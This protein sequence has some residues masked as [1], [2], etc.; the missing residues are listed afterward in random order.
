MQGAAEGTIGPEALEALFDDAVRDTLERFEA[1]GSP[2]ITDGEQRKQ[3]FATYPVADLE[4]ITTGGVTIPFE[5]G[6]ARQLPLITAGPFRYATPAW[7]YLDGARPHTSTKLKQAVISASAVSLMYPPDALPGYPREAFVDDLVAEAVAEI[8]GCLE[9]GADVQ[10]D[11]TE[12]RLSLKLDP[13][14]GLLDSF[15][16][17]NNRVLGEL[18]EDERRRVGVHTCPGGDQDSTHS[19]DVPYEELLP[20]LFR[21][22]VHNFYVQLASEADRGRVLEILGSQAK[23]DRRIF[24]GVID[25]LDPRV[26][27]A[28]EVRDRVLEA[29]R[30]IDPGHL[31]T[32]DDCGFSPFGDDTSTSRDTAFAKIRARV[33]GTAM[34]SSQLGV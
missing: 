28:E 8:R 4:N 10:I 9:R 24:V 32:T 17:L 18:T 30:Y 15:V 7:S 13:S 26:E 21:M 29:A 22:N 31:G 34:A 12:A 2:V 1:T 14:K 25:P 20:S 33:E 3:S 5:D 11:F 19:A 16:D 6:H 27:T 23:G